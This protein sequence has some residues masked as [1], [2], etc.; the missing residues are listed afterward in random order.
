[1]GMS[2]LYLTKNPGT[3]PIALALSSSLYNDTD[4]RCGTNYCYQLVGDY[5]A[6]VRSL[7]KT[8]CGEAFSTA[9]PPVIENIT[10]VVGPEAGVQ[11]TWAI[12]PTFTIESYS[13]YKHPNQ[14]TTP[15]A[16]VNT[17]SFTDATYRPFE[18]MCYEVSYKDICGNESDRSTKVCP[19][20]LKALLDQSN[21]ATLQWTAYTGW[22]SGV[23]HYVVEKY[24]A[25]GNLISSTDVNT[26]SFIDTGSDPGQV[27]TYR[28][29]AIAT[30]GSVAPLPSVSNTQR[31]IKSVNLVHPTAFVPNSNLEDNR[32][33]KVLGVREFIATYELKIFNRW[34]ELMFHTT[35]PE[36]GWDGT[37]KGNK[38]PEGTYV[39]KSRVTDIAGRT[40]DYAGSV[41]LLNKS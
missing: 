10:S 19:V 29:L 40:L 39:F 11:L 18:K 23:D 34:G 9:K 8:V 6:G 28:V 41:I 32:T 2:S 24:D 33:F 27:F 25:T 13:V 14:L 20:E 31:I 30:D 4:I 35:D 15:L 16:T 3:S 21:I 38:M 5:G 22:K 17:P 37:Y 26:T 36:V 1:M 12:D 7:S